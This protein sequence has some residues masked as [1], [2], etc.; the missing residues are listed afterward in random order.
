MS[1][2]TLLDIAKLNGNDK[3]I[4]L[5]EEGIKTCPELANFP[6]RMVKG[7]SY[8]Y[9]AR[10]GRPTV[11][12]RTANNGIDPSKSEFDQRTAQMFILSALVETDKAIADAYEDGPD[13]YNAIEAAGVAQDTMEAIGEQVWYG[14]NAD[15]NGFEGLQSLLGTTAASAGG[16]VIV[17]DTTSGSNNTSVY[18]VRYGDHG[19][20]F[21]FGNY[22]TLDLSDFRVESIVGVNG[23]KHPGYVAD[24][25]GWIGLTLKSL[26][27]AMRI[28]NV[29]AEAGKAGMSDKIIAEAL[30]YWKGAPPDAI[31]MNRK[32]AF[33]LQT[34]RSVTT[35]QGPTGKVSSGIGPFAPAPTESNNIPI[36]ITD[37]LGNSE[38]FLS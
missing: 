36:V 37:A 24:I 18:L 33:L 17:S 7:T 35:M 8:T 19:V 11:G 22:T 15:A 29:R 6:A 3:S 20:G 13:R 23:K 25:S 27:G 34:S 9:V 14:K 30:S 28:A 10:K 2:A 4:G 12:F 32:A 31:Y 16:R 21:D 26:E 5:I 38:S 1:K